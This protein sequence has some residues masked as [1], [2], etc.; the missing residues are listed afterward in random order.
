[1]TRHHFEYAAALIRTTPD[2]QHRAALAAFFVTLARQFNPAF[3][4]ER[5]RAACEPRRRL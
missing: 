4:E 1:M 3:D 2:T 5:F